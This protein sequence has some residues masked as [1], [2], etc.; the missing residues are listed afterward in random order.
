MGWDKSSLLLTAGFPLRAQRVM[1]A[2][3]DGIGKRKQLAITVE[4]DR[5]LCSIKD[6]LAVMATLEM[7]LQHAFQVIVHVPVQIT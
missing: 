5:L 2:L 3:T 6:N 7:N 1:Q 4:F